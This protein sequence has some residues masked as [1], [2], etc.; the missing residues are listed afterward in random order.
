MPFLEAFKGYNKQRIKPG[1][2]VF[3]E[4]GTE[5]PWDFE[6]DTRFYEENEDA[7]EK[8]RETFE[9]KTEEIVTKSGEKIKSRGRGAK[10]FKLAMLDSD[11][12]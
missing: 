5:L 11:S 6:H 9:S 4:D 7:E 3:K 2:N 8:E 12:D 1:I 10:K